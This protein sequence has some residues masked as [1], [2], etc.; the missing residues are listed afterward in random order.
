MTK[1]QRVFVVTEGLH[2][3]QI[4]SAALPG[5]DDLKHIA[6][7][8]APAGGRFEAGSLARSLLALRGSPVVLVV[9]SDTEAPERAEELRRDLEA[10]LGMVADGSRYH[11]AVMSPATECVLF[12]DPK[13]ASAIVGR[14]SIGFSAG[15][16]EH[17]EFV[18]SKLGDDANW[19]SRRLKYLTGDLRKRLR[20]D[21]EVRPIVEFLTRLDKAASR[22][23]KE[24]ADLDAE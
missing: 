14:N 16:C 19:L 11:V 21:D 12:R 17:Q 4:M 7:V 20:R 9:D 18:R 15:K 22:P 24:E 5:K 23:V 1:R 10:S 8:P 13:V 3:S 6:M 2:D